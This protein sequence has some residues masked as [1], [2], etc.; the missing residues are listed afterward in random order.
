MT[1]RPRIVL[2]VHR[3]I[4]RTGRTPARRLWVAAYHGVARA[5]AAYLTWGERDAAT[6]V[7]AGVATG[8]FLPGLADVDMTVVLAQDPAGPG[9]S[10]AR[11]RRRWQRLDRALPV[12]RLLLDWPRIYDDADLRDLA[13]ASAF[14]Y[15]LH[16]PGGPTAG[17][18][19]YFGDRASLDRV[20]ML[21][22]PGLYGATADW[23]L[24]AGPDRRPIEPDRD[25]QSRRIAAW[26][27][28]LYWWRWVFPFC[29]DPT[30]PRTASLCVKLVAEPA[31][32]WLWL[33]HGERAASRADVLRRT[34]R[35]LPEEEDALHRALDLQR[36]LPD[37]PDPPLAEVLPTLL[38][39][40]ARIAGL[41]ASQVAP[42]S[43]TAVRLAGAEPAELVATPR[44]PAP[45]HAPARGEDAG[46][47]PLCDWRSLACP[48]LPDES[49]VLLPGDPGDPAVLSAATTAQRAGSYRAL[50]AESLLILPARSL[51][52]TRLRAIK[53]PTTDPVSFALTDGALMAVF[54]EVRGW[55]AEDTARRAVAEHRT[56]LW[57]QPE[58]GRRGGS[59]DGDGH[60]LGMLLTAARAA[61]FLQSVKE[62]DPELA[63]TVA[64]TARR[65]AAR[66]R[67]AG[68]VAEESLE[69]YRE[70]ALHGVRPPAATISALR[71]LVLGLPAYAEAE[72]RGRA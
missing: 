1:T 31:R 55:S 6:Y 42:E 53:C 54:P 34:V 9:V 64:E 71:G 40:S 23:R 30:Q 13:G 72:G 58:S 67:A 52:R 17:R 49:F 47:L 57:A 45:V 2:A 35:R 46:V 63:L 14:T 12:T 11:A 33:A 60:A 29:V 51:E 65:V 7:R 27:E 32:I 10:C 69:R 56:W 5:G 48:A 44:S 70:F 43:A 37:S 19:A 24:L 39:F 21:E 66:S 68:A 59:A 15:G 41:I 28:L 61:L 25:A 36:S 16:D 26:L 20:R 4:L 50:G 18:G 62:G 22:R 8:D 38:R 3:L